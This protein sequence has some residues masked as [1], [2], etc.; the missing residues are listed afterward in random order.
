MPIIK[1]S[2]KSMKKNQQRRE[3]N[4]SI[5]SKAKTGIKKINE[6][7]TQKKGEEAKKILPHI[8]SLID[9]TAQKGIWHKNKAAREKSKLMKKLSFK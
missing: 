1:S 2:K 7:I 9:N 8:V 5:E 3:R 4:Q 6:L